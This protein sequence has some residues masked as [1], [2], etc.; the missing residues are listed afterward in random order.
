MSTL[1]SNVVTV[2]QS[3][4]DM[5]KAMFVER[6][7]KSA[8]LPAVSDPKKY[9]AQLVS[10]IVNDRDLS[11][12]DSLRSQAVEIAKISGKDPKDFLDR[13]RNEALRAAGFNCSKQEL[14]EMRSFYEMQLNEDP[15]PAEVK[16]VLEDIDFVLA[17]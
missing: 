4:N 16:K 7:R 6:F 3:A 8:I 17:L 2:N 11:N 10:C 9:T 15:N 12:V 13:L 5:Q 1:K 14:S